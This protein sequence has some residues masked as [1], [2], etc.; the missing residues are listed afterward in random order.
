MLAVV[1][2]VGFA[3][4]DSTQ[5]DRVEAIG[6]RIMCPVCQ[7]ESI[8]ASPSETAHAMMEVVREKVTAGESDEQIL[9]YFVAAYGE[10]ILL[11]PPFAG[12]TMAVWLLPIPVIGVGIWMAV[13]RLRQKSEPIS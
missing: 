12:K 2:L 5:T 8:A 9:S 11:D 6:K 7:G 4:G 10:A 1:V 13:S 3:M